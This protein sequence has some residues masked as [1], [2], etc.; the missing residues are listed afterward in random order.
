M[1][2]V[3]TG[4]VAMT[5]MDPK[6]LSENAF[7]RTRKPKFRAMQVHQKMRYQW[8]VVDPGG[9]RPSGMKG[10]I[11]GITMRAARMKQEEAMISDFTSSLV[12]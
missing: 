8:W 1:V 7:A 3:V 5:R 11:V 10:S 6:M 9:N 2:S 4:P 12:R